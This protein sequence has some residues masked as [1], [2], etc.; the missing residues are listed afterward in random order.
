MMRKIDAKA[1][2]HRVAFPLQQNA[3]QLRAVHQQVVG[4]FERQPCRRRPGGKRPMKRKCRDKAKLLGWRIASAQ[5]D[6]RA[7]IKIA[8]LRHQGRS[9]EHT[10]E[11]QSLMRSSYAVFC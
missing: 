6:E 11:I 4:P 10:S 7:C 9:E 8:R 2:D 1:R 5:A 3:A